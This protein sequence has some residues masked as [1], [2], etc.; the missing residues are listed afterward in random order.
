ML[1][2]AIGASGAGDASVA[3]QS[4]SF[5]REF[6]LAPG[7]SARIG[8]TGIGVRFAGVGSDSRC[9]VDV[10]C[11]QAGAAVVRIAVERG[12]TRRDYE[13]ET[14]GAPVRDDDL[15]IALVDLLPRPHSARVI[16]PGDY[17]A[18]VRVRR[19]DGAVAGAP[20]D[21]RLWPKPST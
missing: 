5:D 7:Q 9:P 11:I 14:G 8:D 12:R 16:A 1:A 10:D 4:R 17:R 19:V 18:I 15:T 21:V 2:I 3:G 20:Y 6:T 13:L